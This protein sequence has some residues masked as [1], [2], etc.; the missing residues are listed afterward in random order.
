MKEEEKARLKAEKIKRRNEKIAKGELLGPEDELDAEPSAALGFAKLIFFL[1]CAFLFFGWFI[2]GSALWEYEGKWT[3]WETY[4][5]VRLCH[6][7]H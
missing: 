1:V 6:P 4:F 5:P 3:K 2:T 7:C